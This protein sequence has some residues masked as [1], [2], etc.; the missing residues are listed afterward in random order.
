[1]IRASSPG[2]LVLAGAF[3]VLDGA[4]GVALAV[5]P[6]LS[7][8]LAKAGER[9]WPAAD[10]HA[11]AVLRALA[12]DPSSP[13]PLAIHAAFPVDVQGWSLGSSAAYVTALA[14]ALSYRVGRPLAGIELAA[15]A[16]DA[17]REAQ[18]GVGSGLDVTCCALGGLV[19]FR[20][21]RGC[22]M[23]E[24]AS[25]AWPGH[26]GVVVVRSPS[27][28]GTAERIRCYLG[29]RGTGDS[30]PRRRLVG[31]IEGLIQALLAG[32]DVLDA[33][34]AVGLDEAR[35]LAAA[36]PFMV[37][38]AL[39]AVRAALAPFAACRSV[40]VKSLG[41]GD[42]VGVFLDLRAVPE[43]AVLDALGV[44]GLEARAVTPGSGG[45]RVE[46]SGGASGSV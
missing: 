34:A 45:A 10:P 30:E 8:A 2:K 46:D 16:R 44:A 32:G 13:P 37:P 15:V 3:V 29:R 18:G 20:P 41:A 26:L 7:L 12:L 6:R 36:A 14:A 40:V 42:A 5:S 43:A 4:P 25:L 27:S 24:A 38:V 17:H 21:G 23:P 19:V 31:S 33:L 39:P 11:R 22:V 35:W 28:E 1:M 9:A